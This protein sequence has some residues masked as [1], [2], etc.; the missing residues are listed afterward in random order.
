MLIAQLWMQGKNT[1][2]RAIH[3][4]CHTDAYEFVLWMQGKNTILRAIH[5]MKQNDVLEY[6][7]V[8]A[9]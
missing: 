3:N 6:I 7:T 2:L 1:I 4:K 8:N 5:N 9:G